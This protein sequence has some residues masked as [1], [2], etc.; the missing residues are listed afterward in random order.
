MVCDL[1]LLRFRKSSADLINT[2]R[3]LNSAKKVIRMRKI[4]E[5]FFKFLMNADPKFNDDDLEKIM[6]SAIECCLTELWDQRK[7]RHQTDGNDKN[8]ADDKADEQQPEPSMPLNKYRLT[9]IATSIWTMD[10]QL[11]QSVLNLRPSKTIRSVEYHSIQ[12]L[13]YHGKFLSVYKMLIMLVQSV[14]SVSILT[15]SVSVHGR[16]S[17]FHD[18]RPVISSQNLCVI[19]QR[20]PF[21]SGRS[22]SGILI[23]ECWNR[24]RISMIDQIMH[25]G[26]KHEADVHM[27]LYSGKL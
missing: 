15:M 25:G 8:E 1:R 4:V 10:P 22:M 14:T 6:H 23:H 26:M 3:S 12:R 21:P 7:S 11:F 16:P 17:P 18:R 2:M 20:V 19:G 5:W 13:P 27:A 9:L 24:Y